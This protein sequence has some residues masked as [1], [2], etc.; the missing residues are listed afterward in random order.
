[1]RKVK[2]AIID[3]GI[4]YNIV[5]DDVRNCIKTGYLVHDDEDNTVQEV[6]PSKL[7]DF[8]GHGTVCAS[9]VNRIAPEAEIIPV[10]ILGKNGRCTPGKLVAALE[11]VKRLDVQIIN[12]S[13]SSNDLFIRHKLKKLTKELEAQGKIC[14]ASKSNDRHISFP[15][16]FKNVIGVVGRIDVFNDGFEYDSQKK[17]QVTASG[18]TELMEFHMP[19]ANFFRGNSRAAAI[20]SGVLADAY[21]KGKFSTKAEAEEYMRSESW[22]NEKFYR[23][24]EDDVSDDKIVDRILGLVR[25][26]ISEEKIRVKLAA[27]LELEYTNSTIYDYYKIIYMLENEFSCRIFGKVPVYRVYFQKVNYLGKLV[28]EALNE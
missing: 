20:F 26:M 18:A 23:S 4:N 8:N 21:A 6:S 7:S 11:L 5:N 17:I 10:C 12:M 27:D 15:A 24:P 14:V 22:A 13:L 9:I 25:K 28:K 2:V 16:D 1:M 3:S 19:G